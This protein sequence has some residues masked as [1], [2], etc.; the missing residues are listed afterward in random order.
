M[1][2]HPLH[3]HGMGLLLVLTICASAATQA[4]GEPKPVAGRVVEVTLYRGSAQVVRQIDVPAAA[5]SLELVVGDLPQNVVGST[6]FAESS[7]GLQVRAVRYRRR[8]VGE[9]P[10]EDVRALETKI[11]DLSDQLELNA[12]LQKLAARWLAY[13]DTLEAFVAPPAK[14]DVERGVLDAEALEQITAFSFKNREEASDRSLKLTV[15]RRGLERQ[16]ELA[17]RQLGSMTSGKSRFVHEAVLFL[18][19]PKAGGGTVRLIY[20]VSNCGWSPAYNL[21]AD[22]DAAQVQLEYNAVIQQMSGEDWEN[23]KLTLST[24]S[25]SL[26]AAGPS[27]A[28]L[29]VALAPGP[30][31]ESL[32]NRTAVVSAARS[33]NNTQYA[34]LGNWNAITQGDNIA[35][36][37]RANGLANQY[38]LLELGCASTALDALRQVAPAGDEGASL[39]YGLAARVNL[40]S[41]QDQQMLRIVAAELP[42]KFHHVATPVLTSHVYRE[43]EL[44][45][46]SD[47]DLLTGSVSVYLKGRFVGRT[48]ITTVARG[49]TFLI[50]LGADPQLRASR[51]LLDRT[52]TTQAGN[53]VLNFEYQLVIENYKDAKVAVRLQDRVPYAGLTNQLRVTHGKMSDP[54][55]KDAVHLRLERPRGILRWDLVVDGRASGPKARLL[56][57]AY[58]VEFDRNSQLATPGGQ[59]GQELQQDFYDFNQRRLKY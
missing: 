29:T 9:A 1:T 33:L 47:H 50:G 22:P 46:G 4:A 17:K 32:R 59:K 54:L 20:Q 58:R 57:Y 45:N 39:T 21:R 40:S 27:L 16:M 55:S 3:R 5:G 38:Q 6:L 44:V 53:R 35:L 28:P 41:R 49:Q 30:V 18:E 26:A 15:E 36:G 8:A 2:F 31:P 10:R 42:A 19:K 43:A 7:Q 25:P 24:A 11:Q 14:T 37:W 51:E 48:E 52:D 13:L 23:V 56:E 12:H 34:I